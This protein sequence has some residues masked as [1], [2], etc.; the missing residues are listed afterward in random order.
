MAHPTEA[1]RQTILRKILKISRLL[2]ARDLNI[3]TRDEIDE[4]KLKLQTEITLLWQS[5]EVRFRKVTVKDEIQHGLFFFKEVLYD[6][7]PDF[8]QSLNKKLRSIYDINYASPSLFKFGS[9]VGG[10]RDGHPFVTVDITKNT[11]PLFSAKILYIKYKSSKNSN[12]FLY[13]VPD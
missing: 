8:Y 7:I 3:N 11:L 6:L 12:E 13:P 1:T 2:L 10:D 4:I 5:N 9:W